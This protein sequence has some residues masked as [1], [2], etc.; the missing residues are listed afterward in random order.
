[1]QLNRN[2]ALAL[3]QEYTKSES[4]L[5]HAFAVE[6]SMR[7][8]AKKFNED[9]LTWAIT[10]LLHDFDY[11]KF[12]TAEEHPFKGAEILKGKGYPT[13]MI[14]AI[15][16]HA[17]F[18]GVERKSLLAKTLFA[19]DE[20]SGFLLACA[21]VMPDKKIASLKVKSVKKKLKDKAFARA[22]NRDDII[23]GAQELNVDL[24]EHIAFLI[25]ALN[26]IADKI[27]IW[28]NLSTSKDNI[29]LCFKFLQKELCLLAIK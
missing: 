15:L 4:L 22:V 1:M 19:V 5:K 2:D 27:N 14:E 28:T 10:G 6:E 24:D 13:D 12:P 25:N 3:L 23:K 21:Y 26:E 16:G 18:T 8:Y 29:Y 20:L 7:A 9:E 17:D 11:E